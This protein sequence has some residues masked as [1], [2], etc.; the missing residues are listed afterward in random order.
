MLFNK[1]SRFL[2]DIII[3]LSLIM[4]V[5]T[6]PIY[7]D[8]EPADTLAIK[9]ATVISQSN[10]GSG[11]T[12]IGFEITEEEAEYIEKS[13][14]R[15]EQAAANRRWFTPDA[16]AYRNSAGDGST[17]FFYRQMSSKEKAL[18]D[19]ILA[20]AN[21]F[22]NSNID[23][24][25]SYFAVVDFTPSNFTK[26][27]L[28]K[29]YNLFYHSN[30]KFFFTF[31]GYSYSITGGKLYPMIMDKFK[32]ASVRNSYK[33]QISNVTSQWMSEINAVSGDFAKEEVIYTKL[34]EKIVY[35]HNSPFDQS[36][37]AAIVDGACVCNG[38]AQSMVYFCNLA[39]IDCIMTVSSGHAWNV[40]KLSGKWYYV[41]VTWMDQEA[42]GVWETWCNVES[43]AQ[44][45]AQDQNSNHVF[46]SSLY[47]GIKLPDG[48]ADYAISFSGSG[49]SEG[50]GSGTSTSLKSDSSLTIKS[51][52]MIP[53]LKITLPKSLTFVNNPY[54]LSLD[55]SGKVA[56]SN[57]ADTTNT[58]IV[59]V[60]GTGNS[61]WDIA[62]LSGIGISCM[63]YAT[64]TN[65]NASAVEILD[66]NNGNKNAVTGEPASA[67]K[68]HLKLALLGKV[69]SSG[70]GTAI[71]FAPNGAT[72]W[73]EA[74]G[75]TKFSLIP[76]NQA[77]AVTI[78]TSK[79]SCAVGSACEDRMW[80]VK[81]TASIFI[82]FK[83]DFVG[84]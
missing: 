6:V 41:D 32:S 67:D 25:E 70:S 13:L 62:N 56:T 82:A 12:A 60:Y 10:A 34:I 66:A 80:T 17:D 20:A 50:S 58:Y 52:A 81:D 49:S 69:G 59:P 9:E 31:A 44:V 57:A 65:G 4:G 24:T 55:T 79:S 76:D 68:R 2:L 16:A 46:L 51:T 11:L 1:R 15:D 84:V 73:N 54:R 19:S 22:Y 42:Q 39:D 74:G 63:M 77:L 45:K 5:L 37:A 30:P 61:S 3:S 53:T 35:T 27:E 7:A 71:K 72:S 28:D 47:S 29:V 64:V 43:Y 8:T 78:D 23:V 14:E 18:Y 48:A 40:V 38:Y 75:C 26:D 36:L 83:F 21:E 33:S